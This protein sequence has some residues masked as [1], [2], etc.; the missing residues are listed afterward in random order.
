LVIL[1]G[2][3]QLPEI[4]RRLLDLGWPP[5]LPAAVIQWG[6]WAQQ[7]TVRG[8]LADIARRV[9]REGLGAPAVIIIGDVAGLGKK[10][11]WFEK[12]P[13]FGRTVLVTR[14]RDQASSLTAL[15]EEAGARVIESPLI[16]ITPLPLDKKGKESLK[17]FSDYDGLLV[18]S[19]NGAKIL[20]GHLKGRT[21]PSV[22]A[23]GT[24]TAAAL[25]AEGMAVHRTA[26]NFQSEGLVKTS[27]T[28]S[29]SLKAIL[30]VL[31]KV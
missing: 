8:T 6:S 16:T 14:A 17:R 18:T 15:L 13:L 9:K 5:A 24:K 23:I 3:K 31:A 26:E 19:A 30:P 20:A 11:D 10:L 25:K 22:Y 4:S 21:G 27:S 29:E 7:R 28:N 2:L 1:M 12:R